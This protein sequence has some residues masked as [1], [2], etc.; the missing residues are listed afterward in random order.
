M[1]FHDAVFG[2][3][4]DFLHIVVNVIARK[5]GRSEIEVKKLEGVIFWLLVGSFTIFLFALTLKYS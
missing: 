4:G 3:V 5:L 1:A 2:V